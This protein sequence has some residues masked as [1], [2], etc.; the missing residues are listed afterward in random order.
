MELISKVSK[1]SLMDQV[2]IPKNRYGLSIGSYVV[3]KPLQE[4]TITNLKPFFH[5]VTSLEPVKIRII[6]EIFEDI[7]TKADYENIIVTGSF[8]EKGFNFND[9][10][11]LLIAEGDIEKDLIQESIQ[12]RLGVK[13]HLTVLSSRTLIKGLKTDPLYQS[14]IN[15][16]VSVKRF[17]YG[18]SSEIDYKILDLHL[19]KSKM[20]CDNFDFLSGN[21]KYEML[22][23]MVSIALFI[24]KKNV[25]KTNV[26]MKIDHLFGNDTHKKIKENITIN[27]KEFLSKYKKN[28]DAIYSKILDGIKDASKQE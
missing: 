28:Y 23:N 4:K 9:I 18:L 6:E 13:L 27:K 3:I 17:V 19:M 20:M 12:K 11:V 26:D 7:S 22:R 8:L 2:Y 21:E 1:G 24:D 15:N 14:M 16:C 10:D 25:S 5:N